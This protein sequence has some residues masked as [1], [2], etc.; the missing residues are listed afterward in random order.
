M[1]HAGE[2]LLFRADAGFRIGTGHVMRCLALAQA[3]QDAGGRAVFVSAGLSPLETRLRSEGFAV[4][5]LAE[6]PGSAADA[7]RTV[8]IARRD[9]AEWV[10]LDGY[11]FGDDYERALHTAGLRVFAFDDF[12]HADHR[13][14]DIVLNQNL[15]AAEALYPR[16]GP[17]TQL[18]L[19][20]RFGLLRR[21][22]GKWRGWHRQIPEV[23]RKVLVTLGGSD[24]DNVTAVV[25]DALGRVGIDG[26]EAVVLVGAGNPRYDE[27]AAAARRMPGVRVV[28]S[29]DDMPALMA[30]ADAAIGAGGT[31]AWE[32]AFLQLPSVLVVLAE[33]QREVAHGLQQVGAAVCVEGRDA[34][35]P[36][37]LVAVVR[38]LLTDPSARRR[39]AEVAGGLVDGYGR[40]R[41][42][43]RLRGTPVWLRPAIESDCLLLWEW[44]NDPDVRA[45][46]FHPEP[47]PWENHVRWFAARLED[48]DSR[49]YVAFDARDAPVGQIRFD[50]VDSAEV[51][52][53]V[54]LAREFR[55][56]GLGR[57]VISAGLASADVRNRTVVAR[58]KDANAASLAAFEAVGFQRTGV[59]DV[60]GCRAV[61]L[62][63]TF[64]PEVP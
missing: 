19:G 15:H 23:A 5:S 10:A 4:E 24:P 33:N 64:Q 18:L 49:M 31:T 26:L 32:R 53:G 13:H 61:R 7:E 17:S 41:V 45:M 51:E 55:G 1:A 59:H 50:R 2:S 42:I 28:R 25:L 3:W 62:V 57:A 56:R 47:I 60:R 40:E 54:S 37:R 6:E 48:P 9:G 52:V 34:R 22:F 38:G 14:A 16:R 27:L 8:E 39:A 21:E 11:H 58:V 29:A 46:G 36:D 20:T 35:A 43:A 63:R 44:A 12:G 30:W